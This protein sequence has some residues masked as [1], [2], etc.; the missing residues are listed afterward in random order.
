MPN[1]TYASA[2][3]VRVLELKDERYDPV[4]LDRLLLPLPLARS[5]DPGLR[6]QYYLPLTRP[7]A[8]DQRRIIESSSSTGYSLRS[9]ST[10]MSARPRRRSQADAESVRSLGI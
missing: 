6:S 8:V 3:L 4:E 10:T 5:K 2:P 7:N 1:F 9:F